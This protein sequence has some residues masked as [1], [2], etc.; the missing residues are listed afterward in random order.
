MRMFYIHISTS[1][2]ANVL[3]VA[4]K[5]N[6][7]LEESRELLKQYVS[8]NK[9]YSIL[10]SVQYNIDESNVNLSI[11]PQE[12]LQEL[13]SKYPDLQSSVYAIL[14]SKQNLEDVYQ[15]MFL[16]CFKL[17]KEEMLK[18]KETNDLYIPGFI[19]L[20]IS[21]IKV[22]NFETRFGLNFNIIFSVP[23]KSNVKVQE[24]KEPINLQE[25][26][27][28]VKLEEKKEPV[29]IIKTKYIKSELE[30]YK[31]GVE[32]EEHNEVNEEPMEQPSLFKADSF[33]EPIE[34]EVSSSPD[35][36][37]KKRKETETNKKDKT[38]VGHKRHKLNKKKNETDVKIEEKITIYE[39]KPDLVKKSKSPQTKVHKKNSYMENGYFV[40]EES[41]DYVEVIKDTKQDAE[42]QLS[43]DHNS[44][45][46]TLEDGVKSDLNGKFNDTNKSSDPKKL[47]QVSI[48]LV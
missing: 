40:V 22:R 46:N 41:E 24:K 13:S 7:S 27:E 2:Q 14:S 43:S 44:R 37:E 31:M 38:Q 4:S 16:S 33:D 47:N 29:E 28:I 23:S 5:L 45:S 30:E 48:M 15:N 20:R 19:N 8:K 32:S 6:L 26:K 10:Y 18:C 42:N 25:K 35:T 39:P 11:L 36:S 17:S 12:D 1:F 3:F 34:V 21:N 9:D